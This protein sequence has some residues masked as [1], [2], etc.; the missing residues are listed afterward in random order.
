MREESWEVGSRTDRYK[1]AGRKNGG[2]EITGMLHRNI[3]REG[4]ERRSEKP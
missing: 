4:A 3:P 1:T 2:R